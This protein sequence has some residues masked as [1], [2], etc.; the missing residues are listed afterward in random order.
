MD[1]A[2][3]HRLFALNC[4]AVSML[5]EDLRNSGKNFEVQTSSIYLEVRFNDAEN[6]G[7]RHCEGYII[8]AT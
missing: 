6:R 2:S 5:L 3:W 4:E 7:C 8:N 1:L